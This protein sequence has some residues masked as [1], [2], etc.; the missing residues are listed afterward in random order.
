MK[1]WFFTAVLKFDDDDEVQDEFLT[2][3]KW[4]A[5]DFCDSV[6]YR[7][8]FQDLINDWTI[9]GTVLNNEVMYR[10][11]IFEMWVTVR[12]VSWHFHLHKPLLMHLHTYTGPG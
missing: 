12:S 11:F 1:H 4:Q 2:L 9:P 3:F 5:A 6:I 10:H 8:W 7:S